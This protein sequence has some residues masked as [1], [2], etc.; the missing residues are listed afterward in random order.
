MTKQRTSDGSPVSS[1]TNLATGPV[2]LAIE[3]VITIVG[4]GF[5]NRLLTTNGFAAAYDLWLDERVRRA[6]EQH[7]DPDEDPDPPG[8]FR[9]WFF[10]LDQ[11]REARSERRNKFQEKTP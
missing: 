10:Y 3:P 5:P 1:V 9:R 11:D 2:H 4:P 8:W 7:T 6:M